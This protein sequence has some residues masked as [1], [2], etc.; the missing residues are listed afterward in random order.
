MTN[1]T[2]QIRVASL[3]DCITPQNMRQWDWQDAFGINP[4]AV[5][6]E[7][8]Q[9]RFRDYYLDL[10]A[11]GQITKVWSTRRPSD[12]ISFRQHA[13]GPQEIVKPH[14]RPAQL[15]LDPQHRKHMG[16]VSCKTKPGWQKIVT[17]LQRLVNLDRENWQE[18]F[19]D[20]SYAPTGSLSQSPQASSGSNPL[21][22]VDYLM[23]S[24]EEEFIPPLDFAPEEA[25]LVASDVE[26]ITR[27]AS[28]PIVTAMLQR[29][30]VA[31]EKAKHELSVF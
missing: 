1:S 3:F 23:N 9:H 4:A 7:G 16:A 25:A 11:G 31:K 5:N 14:G 2:L 28:K 19:G 18:K 6:L 24:D 12:G 30:W 22:P 27:V 26:K 17:L 20:Q 10:D 21:S 8:V 13:G 15:K 29:I